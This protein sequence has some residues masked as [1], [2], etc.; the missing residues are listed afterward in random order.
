MLP[1]EMRRKA[2]QARATAQR[3]LK[4]SPELSADADVLLREVEAAI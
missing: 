2:R 4:Q 1:E 3:L